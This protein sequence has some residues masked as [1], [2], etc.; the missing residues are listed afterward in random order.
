MTK[1]NNL[2]LVLT[3]LFTA[4]TNTDDTVTDNTQ[5]PLGTTMLLI[6]NSFFK[7]YASQLDAMAVEAGYTNHTSTLVFAGGENGRPINLWETEDSRHR[8][9]KE[10]LDRGDISVFGMTA[11]L[12]PENPTDGFSDWIAY[13]LQNNPDITIFLSIPPPDFPNQ[14]EQT[15]ADLGFETIAEAYDNFVNQTV[16][17]TLIDD[18]RA[19][20]PGTTIFSIPTGRASLV[21]RE[22][23]T[24]AQLLD[25]IVFMGPYQNGLFTDEKGHQGKLI[26]MTGALMWLNGIYKEDLETNDFSTGFQ[27]DVHAIAKA[28]MT[29]HDANYKR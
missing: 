10:A 11:G 21:L 14:W 22:M 13:A 7:P 25:D 29:N 17:Q 23:H 15:A 2:L 26:T 12:L 27:T 6:G 1:L 28:E 4:C 3:V 19:E 24:N 20:F 5:D 16:N 18:L 8:D 9:I